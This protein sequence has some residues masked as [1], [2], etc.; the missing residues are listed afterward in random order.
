MNKIALTAIAISLLSS[1]AMSDSQLGRIMGRHADSMNGY[2]NSSYQWQNPY[3][4]NS[5]QE[6][7]RRY[8]EEHLRLLREQNYLLE[9]QQMQQ[10]H[11]RYRY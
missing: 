5:Q 6:E 4:G 10:N 9:D 8:Q 7:T 1:N 11:N 2:N 3:Y